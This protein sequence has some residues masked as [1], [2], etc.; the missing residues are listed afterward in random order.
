VHVLLA[1]V[2]YPIAATL[3]LLA[4]PVQALLLAA[5]APFDPNRAVAGR[6]LRFV[7]VGLSLTFPPWRLRVEG[8]WPERAGPFVV[9]ANHQSMLDIL[10]LSR[11]PREMKW[12]AKAS[13]WRVPWAG[14]MLRMSG[15]IPVH[16][17]DAE[18]GGEALSRARAYLE[19]GMSVMV[20]PEGTRSRDGGLLPFKAGAFR[21]AADA[22][23]PVLPVA[24]SGTAAGLP[25]GGPWVRPCR[26][27]AR[28]L[29]PI[30]PAGKGAP[31]AARLSQ[32]A[33]AQIAAALEDLRTVTTAP[34]P[35]PVAAAS[36]R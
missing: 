3:F 14:W 12:I 29:E 25:K 13:L 19:R 5:T 8:R 18:S 17:G 6:F 23:I 2:G 31:E 26:A 36:S 15:D 34:Q 27:V 7:G 11:L 32:A 4:L 30:E 1:I 22:G 10:L 20:F 35:R 24:V 21:L 33:R 16:R 9:V 28:I